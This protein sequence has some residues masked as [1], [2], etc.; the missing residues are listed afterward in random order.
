MNINSYVN[1]SKISLSDL[2]YIDFLFIKLILS[3]IHEYN[4]YFYLFPCKF[5]VNFF[6]NVNVND[7][8]NYN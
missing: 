1:Q 3:F 7:A 4:S 8:F 5:S 2:K 6:L